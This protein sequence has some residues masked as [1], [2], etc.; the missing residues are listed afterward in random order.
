MKKAILITCT[1]ILSISFS[2]AQKT[3]TITVKGLDIDNF[4]AQ[5]EY[6]YPSYTRAKVFLKDGDIASGRFNYD[7]FSQEMKY[8]GEKGDT[9]A[10]AN[11]HDINFIAIGTDS[12]FYNKG[13]YE[14]IASSG[15]ARLAVKHIFKLVERQSVGPFGISSATTGIQKIGRVFGNGRPYDLLPNEELVFS[16]ETTFYISPTRGKKNDFVVANKNNIDKLFP[17]INIEE[18]IKQN[19]INLNNVE[20]LLLLMVYISKTN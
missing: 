7:Y 4:I 9:L 19:K 8:I 20:D 5:T 15:I 1:F 18:F 2:N 16:K 17:K 11:E 6:K 13:Y 14:W 3:E 12:F 10:I